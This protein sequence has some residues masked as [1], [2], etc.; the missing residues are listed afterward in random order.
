MTCRLLARRL[1]VLACAVAPAVAACSQPPVIVA[2]TNAVRDV[3]GSAPTRPDSAP[4]TAEDARVVGRL[5]QDYLRVRPAGRAPNPYWRRDEQQRFPWFDLAGVETYRQR[6]FRDRFGGYRV[7][8][9]SP[10]VGAEP[11][12]LEAVIQFMPRDAVAGALPSARGAD[13]RVHLFAR[14]ERGVWRLGSALPQRTRGWPETVVG[15]IRY[16]VQPGVALDSALAWSGASFLDSLA[17]A[18]GVAPPDEV[19]Y[20]LTRS[21]ADGLQVMGIDDPRHRLGGLHLGPNRLVI[22]AGGARDPYLRHEL[23]HAALEGAGD[24][25]LR[26]RLVVEGVAEWVSWREVP[27]REWGARARVRQVLARRRSLTLAEVVRQRSNDGDGDA[28]PDAEALVYPTGAWLVGRVHRVAGARG[29]RDLLEVRQRDPDEFLAVARRHLNLS[30]RAL[31][32]AW[33]A[34]TREAGNTVATP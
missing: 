5:V 12:T 25:R 16:R 13:A 4:P 33:R 2:A 7:A 31:E 32:D 29:V 15:R 21:G 14:R 30:P 20:V 1:A 26:Q 22:S 10:P 28:D 8:V 17:L 34:W 3:A 11:G 24:P 9:A 18:F 6:Y 27:S 19:L 23:T